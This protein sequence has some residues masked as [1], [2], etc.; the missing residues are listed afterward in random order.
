M[1][2]NVKKAYIFFL[3]LYLLCLPLGAINIGAFGSALKILSV[4]PFLVAILGMKHI[5]ITLPL[6]RYFLYA[7]MVAFSIIISTSPS[8]SIA[9]AISIAEFFLLMATT[10]CFSFTDKDISIIKRTLIWSSRIS[11]I[12][13][14]IW[15]TYKAGRLW[16]TGG[17]INEDPN[18]FCMYL[19]F[20]VIAAVQGLMSKLPW[21]KKIICLVELSVYVVIVLLT[22]SRGGL[23]ALLFGIFAFILFSGK[24]FSAKKIVMI[25]VIGL[26]LYI[27]IESLS[28]IL[29]D[30]F[31]VES[32]LESGGS[33][34]IDIWLQGLDLFAN[35][36]M[37]RKIFGYG[38]A[39]T[40]YNFESGGYAIANVMHNMFLESLVEIGILGLILYFTMVFSFLR[41]AYKNHDKFSF[42][43]MICMI[44]MSLST[45]ISAF[46]PYLNIMIFILCTCMCKK[47]V[48]AFC[49]EKNDFILEKEI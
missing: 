33:H 11:A 3:C 8:D 25:A 15:G 22:G 16:L 12:I 35:A 47:K 34:R 48:E 29:Q 6:V 41:R 38:I 4:F 49:P 39:T 10:C 9:K 13:V 43:V 44:V 14:L 2:F 20:G 36:P 26:I 40:I 24:K 31:T 42:G 1:T 45:S 23:L 32:V 46:K 21:S 5:R 17:I 28:D 7:L 30:R 18:Y 37:F 27:G 19:S